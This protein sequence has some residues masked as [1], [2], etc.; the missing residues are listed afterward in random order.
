MLLVASTKQYWH[1]FIF[2]LLSS[3]IA[4]Y[5]LVLLQTSEC[6]HTQVVSCVWLTCHR[7]KTKLHNSFPYPLAITI[8]FLLHL[9]KCFPVLYVR[10]G[11]KCVSWGCKSCNQLVLAFWLVNDFWNGHFLQQK[12][13]L[14]CRL[15]SISI[16]IGF[17]PHNGYQF[18]TWTLYGRC[19]QRSI[20][21]S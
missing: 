7:E 13:L 4:M 2:Y 17:L 9:L 1:Y 20:C 16:C 14:V 18:V 21:L 8:F 6:S 11:C 10:V 15:R 3:E 5:A 19:K 12:K